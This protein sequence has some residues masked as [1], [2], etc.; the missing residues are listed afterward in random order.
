MDRCEAKRKKWAKH[1][2]CVQNMEGKPW[3][4]E[5]LKELEEALTRLKECEL[6]KAS[7]LYKE[8]TGVECDGFHPRIP[9]D[10]TKETRRGIVEILEKATKVGSGRSKP[11]QR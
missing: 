8:K 1:R 10:L 7:R 9:L 5:E 11:A 4:N 6:E 2:Q 3:T